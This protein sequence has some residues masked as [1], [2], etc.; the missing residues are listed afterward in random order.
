MMNENDVIDLLKKAGQI[1]VDIWLDGDWG[2][3]T[4]IERQTRPHNNIDIL[5]VAAL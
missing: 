5:C 2:V 4:L 1:G 3:D